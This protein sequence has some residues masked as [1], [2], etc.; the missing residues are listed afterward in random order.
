[1]SKY[2]PLKK[3]LENCV[4]CCDEMKL[5]LKQMEIIL[6]KKLPE[7]AYVHHAWWHDPASHPHVENWEDLGWKVSV[8]TEKGR[9]RWVVF[10]KGKK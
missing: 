3:F 2:D 7:S 5:T 1:M 6:R 9:I 10:R 4:L 8:H